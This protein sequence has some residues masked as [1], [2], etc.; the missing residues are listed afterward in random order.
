MTIIQVTIV[1]ISIRDL[2]CWY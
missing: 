2:E 1:T